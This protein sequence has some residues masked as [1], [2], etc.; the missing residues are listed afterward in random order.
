MAVR[1]CLL[2]RLRAHTCLKCEQSQC[3][4]KPWLLAKRQVSTLCAEDARDAFDARVLSVQ[5]AA[6]RE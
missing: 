3:R 2:R 6:A 1:S 5:S 4:K